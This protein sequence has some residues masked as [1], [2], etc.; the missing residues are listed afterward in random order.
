M[1]DLNHKD[2][3][4]YSI[5]NDKDSIEKYKYD[6]DNCNVNII[7]K[8]FYTAE[9]SYN[10]LELIF[11]NEQSMYAYIKLCIFFGKSD[12]LSTLI[13]KINLNDVTNLQAII[14]FN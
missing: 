14:L 11:D 2:E 5:W 9:I 8:N 3:Y 6:L 12:C 13:N 10:G 1:I 7:N 4:L